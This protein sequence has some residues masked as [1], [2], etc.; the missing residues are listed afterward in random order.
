[1]AQVGYDILT[2]DGF[3]KDVTEEFEEWRKA[4]DME[5]LKVNNV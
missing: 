2:D 4:M 5:S 3:S 1:L